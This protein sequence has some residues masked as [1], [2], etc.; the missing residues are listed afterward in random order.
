[1]RK[2]LL[3][4]VLLVACVDPLDTGIVVDREF[5]P[6]HEEEYDDTEYYTDYEE[7]CTGSY[8]DDTRECHMDFVTNSRTVRRCCHTIPDRWYLTVRGGEGTEDGERSNR[9][10]VSEE[11]Y[12]A[13][14]I[15]RRWHRDEPVCQPQ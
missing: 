6:E 10:R 5:E 4:V 14:I 1:M 13:C 9:V 11:A 12:D 7:V 2:A 15:G 3:L 8:Y